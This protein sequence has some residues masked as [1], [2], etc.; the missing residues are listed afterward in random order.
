M[1]EEERREMT[2]NNYN[3]LMRASHCDRDGNPDP[4]FVRV[5]RCQDCRWGLVGLGDIGRLVA[6]C[7]NPDCPIWE[8]DQVVEPDWYCPLGERGK[9]E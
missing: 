2:R 6:Y 1:T 7:N 4:D 3:A 5:V 9:V 8:F